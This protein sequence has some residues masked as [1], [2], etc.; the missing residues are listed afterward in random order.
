MGT[1]VAALLVVGVLPALT[2][3]AGAVVA[4]DKIVLLGSAAKAK[5]ADVIV[6]NADGTGQRFV[7]KGRAKEAP[8]FASLAPTD[9]RIVELF[10]TDA[11]QEGP[12][13]LA[14]MN[15]D[16]SNFRVLAKGKASADFGLVRWNQAG[17]KLLVSVVDSYG[18][19]A[20]LAI[21]NTTLAHPTL[22]RL[23]GSA[24]LGGASFSTLS[25]STVVAGDDNGNIVTL[26]GGTTTTVVAAGD[27][28]GYFDPSFSPGDATIAVSAFTLT[29]T[30]FVSQIATMPASGPDSTHPLVVLAGAGYN[31]LPFWSTDGARVYYSN[32]NIKTGALT[33]FVV[34]AG[35]SGSPT[36]IA[37]SA[38]KMYLLG[39][40]AGPDTTAPGAA[41]SVRVTLNGSTPLVSWKPP[42][43]V[44]VSH[45]VVRRAEGTTAPISPTDGTAVYQGPK[46]AIVDAV[47]PGT[48]YTYAVWAVDGSGNQSATAPAQTYVAL[49]APV[50]KTPPLVSSVS[51]DTTFLVSWAPKGGNPPGTPYLVQ[52]LTSGGTW[53]TWQ[54]S[55]TTTSATFGA[56]G[57]PVAPRTGRAYALRAFVTD[58]YGNTSARTGLSWVEPK[59]DRS[60]NAKGS[61]KQA[62]SS[63]FWLGTARTTTHAKASLSIRLTGSR[64]WIVGDRLAHGSKADVFVDNKLVATID[65]HGSSAHRQVLWTKKVKAGKHVVRVVNLATHGRQ[66]LS[67]DGF[68]AA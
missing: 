18:D 58:I 4:Q 68:A 3:T 44:D 67:I 48:T 61:W 42:A 36:K 50:L 59:D 21:V 37:L 5:V 16:G 17:T 65:T 43:D 54:D 9:N 14:V 15:V 23:K 51:L 6:A 49:A 45:F 22:V 27:T 35:G 10:T 1:C 52:W 24:G 33:P 57:L 26:T 20:Y 11:K 12:S 46:T 19:S 13:S 25:D 47:T 28:S 41:S 56:G 8:N 30:T 2:A 64:L 62:T 60:A 32:V 55:V 7:R 66:H 39:G 31:V 63:A 29:E 38:G 34:P 40:V 53:V